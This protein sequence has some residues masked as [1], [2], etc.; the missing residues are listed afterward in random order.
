LSFGDGGESLALAVWA[1]VAFIA[2]VSF[3][4]PR[5]LRP[6]Y[7]ALTVLAFP[8]GYVVSHIVLALLFFG[9]LTPFGLLFRVLGR[10]PLHRQ[11]DEDLESYWVPRGQR[12]KKESYFRQF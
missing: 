4:A 5:L 1:M 12:P 8:I 2:V 6:L 9:L 3:A 11:F 10:D 7:V